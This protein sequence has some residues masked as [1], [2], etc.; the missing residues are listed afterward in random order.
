MA[1]AVISYPKGDFF[2]STGLPR[3]ST[4]LLT[5]QS[6]CLS[7][8]LL[9]VVVLTSPQQVRADAGR[10]LNGADYAELKSELASLQPLTAKGQ[11][12]LT[13]AQQQRLADLQV[14]ERTI[15]RSDDRAQ[16]T[17]Q[18]THNLGLFARYKKD[19]SDQPP[20]FYVL[21]PGH[22]SDDDFDFVALLVPQG[23]SLSWGEQGARAARSNG[24]GVVRILEGQPL[25]VSEG[26]VPINDATPQSTQSGTPTS[27]A[28]TTEPVVSYKLSQPPFQV[29]DHWEPALTLPQLN[30]SAL[31]QE[32]ENAPLD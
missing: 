27:K 20:Q 9:A 19:P 12:S 7:F 29:L 8:L 16:L 14:L 28:A 3:R 23:V 26:S 18:T 22:Q 24:P 5:F 2:K 11:Q 32:I 21:A 13:S 6:I 17:N 30:Q 1:I 31:D 4:W 15:A 25:T 10:Y